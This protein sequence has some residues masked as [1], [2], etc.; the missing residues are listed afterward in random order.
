MVSEGQ[1]TDEAGNQNAHSNTLEVRFDP[2]DPSVSLSA[3]IGDSTI[4]EHARTKATTIDYTI[5]TDRAPTT[6]FTANL[7]AHNKANSSVSSIT[8]PPSRTPAPR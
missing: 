3:K 1:F 8:T 4:S 2:D 6:F 5:T 7:R